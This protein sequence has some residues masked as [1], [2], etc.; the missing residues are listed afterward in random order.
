VTVNLVTVP[1][2]NWLSR[3]RATSHTASLSSFL[4]AGRKNVTR[5]RLSR[6][7][8]LFSFFLVF[9]FLD[10]PIIT[11]LIKLLKNNSFKILT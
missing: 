7:T 5:T 8:G 2:R 6:R 10:F 3:D 1:T 9:V 11:S 4:P